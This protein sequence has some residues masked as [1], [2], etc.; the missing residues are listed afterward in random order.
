MH[1]YKGLART[2]ARWSEYSLYSEKQVTFEEDMGAYDQTDAQGFI[3]LNGLRLR[4]LADRKR[5]HKA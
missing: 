1:L 5:K 3:A 4:L 2:V